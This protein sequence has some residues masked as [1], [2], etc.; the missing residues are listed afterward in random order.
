MADFD[1]MEA[2]RVVLREQ[3]LVGGAPRV[4]RE[5]R[6]AAAFGG[7]TLAFHRFLE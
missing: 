7:M 6:L 2:A 1:R 3:G 4:E 5:N